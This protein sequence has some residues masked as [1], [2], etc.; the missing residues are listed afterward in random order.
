MYHLS[1]GKS[2]K[3]Q[4]PQKARLLGE[5]EDA[6]RSLTHKEDKMRQ[7]VERMQRLEEAQE[8]K[9]QERRWELP[10]STR[11]SMHY[12][13]Q[14]HDWRVHNFDKRHHQHQQQPQHSFDFVK[15]PSFS[16]SNDPNLYLEWEAKVEHLFNV[17]KVT[18]DQKVM[19]ASLVFLDYAI[20][21][22][23]RIDGHWAKQEVSRGLLV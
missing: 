7:L 2:S 14:E 20:Q 23:Q 11:H 8:R 1:L 3:P 17:Y 21:W 4:F 22:W 5:L 9:Y 12:E 19:L 13:S 18:E 15:L 16:G 6:R 10:R